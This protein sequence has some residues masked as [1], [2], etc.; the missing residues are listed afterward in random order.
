MILE[1]SPQILAFNLA[2]EGDPIAQTFAPSICFPFLFFMREGVF[3]PSPM[4]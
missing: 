1:E 3:R 4:F 2:I